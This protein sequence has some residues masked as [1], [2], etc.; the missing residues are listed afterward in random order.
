MRGPTLL[1]LQVVRASVQ[2]R[3]LR[4]LFRSA[5][6]S[7]H[8]QQ[9]HPSACGRTRAAGRLSFRLIQPRS[10]PPGGVRT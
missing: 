8:A 1:M 2:F 3:A 4:S 5:L 9:G 6:E 7:G 10:G